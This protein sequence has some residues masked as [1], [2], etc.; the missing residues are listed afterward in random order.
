MNNSVIEHPRGLF[1]Y[2]LYGKINSKHQK[3]PSGEVNSLSFRRK[4]KL[5]LTSREFGREIALNN[6]LTTYNYHN[7]IKTKKT[8][9]HKILNLV[10]EK[11]IHNNQIR[12]YERNIMDLKRNNNNNRYLKNNFINKY[13]ENKE[14]NINL[15]NTKKNIIDDII[16]DDENEDKDNNS[17]IN[18]DDEVFYEIKEEN[19]NNRNKINVPDIYNKYPQN[20]DEY[21]DDIVSE[22]KNKEEKYLP[23]ENYMANQKDINHRMRAILIDWLIDVHIKYKMVP[24]TMYISVNLI[25]RFLSENKTNRDK[26]QLVGVASMFIASKYEEIYPPEL[27][28]FV[29]ITDKAYVKSEVLEMEYKMLKYLNFDITFPTQWS[30]LEIFKK[31]LD[32]DQKTFY[33]AW[34]LM[35]LSLINYKMLKF[36]YSQIAASAVLIAIKTLNY[37]NIVEFEKNTGYN[38]KDIEECV[39]EIINFNIYNL[40]HSL[41][42]IRKKFSTRKYDEVSKIQVY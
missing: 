5:P 3:V 1:S 16:I 24:Q 32:L 11:A 37:F 41:Q 26:L 6:N 9:D 12:N 8:F 35:E 36:K 14:N 38:E 10:R 28:D 30:F 18:N 4:Y 25:D 13:I 19:Q 7:V 15:I 21:F 20:V 34:F 22:L 33:L 29:Y 23:K 42:A 39:K 2:Q 40:T 17:I 31:K 27:K